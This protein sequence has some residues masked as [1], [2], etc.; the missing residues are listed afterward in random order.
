MKVQS[1]FRIYYDSE[2]MA[3]DMVIE[4]AQIIQESITRQGICHLVFPGGRSPRRIL[5]LLREQKL[6]W[7]SLHLYPG[8]ER[9]VP[10]GDPERNDRLIDELLLTQVP[11]PPE[12]LHRIHAEL[13]PEEGA[14]LYNQLL[15]QTPRFD[16]ALL[17]IGLDGHTASLFPGNPALNDTRPAVAVYNAPKP[18]SERVSIGLSHL[19]K[20]R[21]RW[22]IVTGNEKQELMMRIQHGEEFPITLVHPTRWFIDGSTVK[23]SST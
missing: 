1:R 18:P 6:T 22:V 13:G 20:A 4:L 7:A 8:D 21:E 11:L 5:E 17:G 2:E 15:A 9:C 3:V 23:L 14:R 10:I 19:R 16:I 12:N